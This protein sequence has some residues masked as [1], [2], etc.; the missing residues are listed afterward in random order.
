[1]NRVTEATTRVRGSYL[2]FG[3]PP[4]LPDAGDAMAPAREV[5]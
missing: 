1:M 2:T 4:R 5:E 3:S